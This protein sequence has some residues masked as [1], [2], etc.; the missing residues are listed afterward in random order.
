MKR[1]QGSCCPACPY[2]T[3]EYMIVTKYITL[4]EP[5]RSLNRQIQKLRASDICSIELDTVI[6]EYI[7]YSRLKC[8][9]KILPRLPTHAIPRSRNSFAPAMPLRVR[10]RNG[11]T[12]ATDVEKFETGV[13]LSSSVHIAP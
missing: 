6:Y 10:P 13:P 11:L 2:I 3:S 9:N 7:N 8:A 12:H 5:A 4:I 1:R